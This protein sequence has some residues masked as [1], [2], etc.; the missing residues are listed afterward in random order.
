[1]KKPYS[2][3]RKLSLGLALICSSSAYAQYCT[4]NLYSYG[5]YYNDYVNSVS[6]T[7]GTTNISNNNNGCPS[8]YTGYSNYTSSGSVTI[9][10][11][12]SFNLT[13]V[14]NPNYSEWYAVYVDWNAD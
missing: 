2:F 12:S 1:M 14:N 13:V 4:S 10:K 11:G 5:C 9:M 6:T 3:L 7:G 8:S